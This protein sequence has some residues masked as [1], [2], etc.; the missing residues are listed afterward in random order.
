MVTGLAADGGEASVAAALLDV[1]DG[2]GDGYGAPSSDGAE[3]AALLAEDGVVVDTTYV[4][5]AAGW[6]LRHGRARGLRRVVLWCSFAQPLLGTTAPAE[7]AGRLL[8]PVRAPAALP[9][10]R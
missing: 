7:L 8:R 6:V 1:V 2:V 4:A 9:R 10:G 3:A 5:K